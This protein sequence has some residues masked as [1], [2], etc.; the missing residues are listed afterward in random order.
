MADFHNRAGC[1]AGGVLSKSFSYDAGSNI[2]VA[3]ADHLKKML[4]NAKENQ[5]KLVTILGKIFIK[6]INKVTRREEYSLHPSL[7]RKSL[8]KIVIETRKLIMNLYLDCEK[9]FRKGIKLFEG[10]V[11]KKEQMRNEKRR[12][13]LEKEFNNLLK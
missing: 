4:N 13:H 9:D 10:L 6:K 8:D 5:N 1:Q 11:E 2:Y 7:T 3:Y 12:V